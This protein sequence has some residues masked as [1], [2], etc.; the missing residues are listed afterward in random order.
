M[1]VT[2]RTLFVFENAVGLKTIC[3]P[4]W[5]NTRCFFGTGA[6][7][8]GFAS[9]ATA[10]VAAAAASRALSV[11]G[12]PGGGAAAEAASISPVSRNSAQVSNT[13]S[14]RETVQFFFDISCHSALCVPVCV[15]EPAQ[16]PNQL[17]SVRYHLQHGRTTYIYINV[18]VCICIHIYK[19]FLYICTRILVYK[20]M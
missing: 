9:T 3:I 7:G 20:Y 10:D 14:L 4:M 13:L 17:W 12:R 1:S 8:A 15:G 16:W 2:E 11:S 19:H 5:L 6:I 18:H